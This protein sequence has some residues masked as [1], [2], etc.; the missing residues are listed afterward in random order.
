MILYP[1]CPNINFVN[2]ITEKDIVRSIPSDNSLN[3]LTSTKNKFEPN[4]KSKAKP[5]DKKINLSNIYRELINLLNYE[6]DID[7]N[8]IQENKEKERK[9]VIQGDYKNNEIDIKRSKEQSDNLINENIENIQKENENK[10]EIKKKINKKQNNINEIES[11]KIIQPN[12]YM[13]SMNNLEKKRSVNENFGYNINQ[14]IYNNFNIPH[15]NFIYNF[16]VS[17]TNNNCMNNINNINLALFLYE[18]SKHILKLN[19]NK[20]IM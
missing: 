16:G 17:G 12:S 19:F 11:T 5:I 14:N 18:I 1:D 3:L 15:V 8:L 2:S 6:I 13:N 9:N 4:N 10:N 7:Q 20:L